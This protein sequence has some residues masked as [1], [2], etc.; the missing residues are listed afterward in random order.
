MPRV[1]LQSTANSEKHPRLYKW[2]TTTKADRSTVIREALREHL[3]NESQIKEISEQLDRI[4]QML[5]VLIEY[6]DRA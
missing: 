6:Q 4:E 3:F 1:H 2:W 5:E